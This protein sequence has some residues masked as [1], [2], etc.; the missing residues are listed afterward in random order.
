MRVVRVP[1]P[2]RETRDGVDDS[3][4]RSR[5]TDVARRARFWPRKEETAKHDFP[6]K[7]S[8]PVSENAVSPVAPIRSAIFTVKLSFKLLSSVFFRVSVFARSRHT[9]KSKSAR[10]RRALVAASSLSL[11][12]PRRVDVNE[13]TRG[14]KSFF[15][16]YNIA[17]VT[18]CLLRD[19]ARDGSTIHPPRCVIHGVA[20]LRLNVRVDEKPA[21]SSSAP[22]T[23]RT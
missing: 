19:K 21:S 16:V 7:R 4:K 8:V 17:N 23:R 18:R 6:L 1:L 12:S 10:R 15:S 14:K 13:S 11:L 3:D 2:A 22:L 20:S 5:Q 9:A